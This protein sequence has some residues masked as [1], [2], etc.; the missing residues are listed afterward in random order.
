ML[1]K[2]RLKQMNSH[3]SFE[4]VIDRI[5]KS[6]YRWARQRNLAPPSYSKD[7][8]LNW[9]AHNKDFITSFN[10]YVENEYNRYL[11][12]SIDTM[13][14]SYNF[15]LDTIEVG[16]KDL[17]DIDIAKNALAGKYK[18]LLK[19][20]DKNCDYVYREYKSIVEASLD[21]EVSY[22]SLRAKVSRAKGDV[23]R[24]GKFWLKINQ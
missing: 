3:K 15:T 1:E 12:P 18:K 21:L 5:Y 8:L 22:G 20:K 11:L 17:I 2:V 14:S 4:G 19:C 23:F 7:E 24:V 13:D 16:I 10:I 6:H 9:C